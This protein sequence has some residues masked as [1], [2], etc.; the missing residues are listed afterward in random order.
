[1]SDNDETVLPIVSINS[2]DSIVVEGSEIILR[3][4]VGPNPTS[5]F[6]LNISTVFNG[7]FFGADTTSLRSSG[8]LILNNVTQSRDYIVQ[9][10]DDEV[11][12]NNGYVIFT[13]Q[14][15]SNYQIASFPYNS[16]RVV[17]EDND[18]PAQVPIISI[19]T[20]TE[21]VDEGD[22]FELV[23]NSTVPINYPLVVDV[24]LTQANAVDTVRA[25]FIAG[26][27]RQLFF[28]NGSTSES[29]S[30][31]IIDDNVDEPDGTI[32]A[33]LATNS[34]YELGQ[35]SS[36]S[37][38]IVDNDKPV[39]SMR[40]A[41]EENQNV[42]EG[43]LLHFGVILDRISWHPIEVN[44]NVSQSSN[45]GDFINPDDVGNSSVTV[46]IGERVGRFRV[47]TI[48][49]DVGEE[50]AEITATILSGDHYT[51]YNSASSTNPNESH[52]AT[53]RVIDNDETRPIVSISR[54]K[55]TIQ[56]GEEASFL[57]RIDKA[58]NSDLDVKVKIE[59]EADAGSISGDI[60][61]MFMTEQINKMLSPNQNLPNVV[62]ISAGETVGLLKI[63]TQNDEVDE[64]NSKIFASLQE[65]D[66]YLL[67]TNITD[68]SDTV[69]VLDNDVP[70]L[71]ISAEFE[72]ISE[73]GQ[74]SYVQFGLSSAV[75]IV[76]AL[77]V[78]VVINQTGD[79]IKGGSG[80]ETAHL[81]IGWTTHI[82]FVELDDDNKDEIDGQVSARIIEP[83]DGKYDD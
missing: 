43:Q 68:H 63:P 18:E 77:S 20:S 40:A 21:S 55:D 56:E 30:I 45:G 24:N 49:D 28:S 83:S 59:S 81:G 15:S 48:E 35:N 3:I 79:F 22:S 42:P 62:K 80:I 44:V 26:S 52:S 1:M 8:T 16:T 50:S 69:A 33:T 14:A 38:A 75:G 4:N 66:Q 76:E 46:D 25:E 7:N 67:S 70:L 6:D 37:I 71:S 51:V 13:I 19:T 78:P 39:A 53:V 12:E 72:S 41:A 32:L 29:V 60:N 65:S 64:L 47:R 31:P 11:D 36:V 34:F 5:A 74:E 17:V 27:N 57:V 82:I 2:S 23:V 73:S 54:E 10:I 61:L 58:I 9:T